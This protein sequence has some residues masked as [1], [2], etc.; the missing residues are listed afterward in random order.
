MK[1]LFERQSI[2]LENGIM[3]TYFAYEDINKEWRYRSYFKDL[4]NKYLFNP[5]V[6]KSYVSN[7]SI[8]KM[9]EYIISEAEKYYEAK[10]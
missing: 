5:I 3:I 2:L 4:N 1:E 9:L 10:V 8:E 7:S 6:D